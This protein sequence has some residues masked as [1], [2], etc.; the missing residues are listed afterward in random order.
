[1]TDAAAEYQGLERPVRWETLPELGAGESVPLAA[2]FTPSEDVCVFA[3]TYV[4]LDRARPIALFA[5]GG[6]AMR[7]WWNGEVVLEDP[8]YRGLAPDRVA[9][10]A[11]G[12]AGWNRV[13]VKL[14]SADAGLG[15]LLR[16]AEPD[17]TPISAVHA[18]PDGARAP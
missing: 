1:E 13:L 3:E 10:L 6:G 5:G 17:G 15:L 11:V 2:F 16:I 8:V 4:E 7:I 14:C 9:A 12:R 18:D